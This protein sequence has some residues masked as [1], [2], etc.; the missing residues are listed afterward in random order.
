MPNYRRAHVPGGTYFFTV[1]TEL[2][3]PIFNDPSNASR[4]GQIIRKAITRWPFEIPAMVL[5]P[6]H[7]HA[8]WALPPGVAVGPVVP[9][10]KLR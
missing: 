2:N 7:L 6:D 3:T 5:L 8:I 4:L 1:K 9:D 10:V